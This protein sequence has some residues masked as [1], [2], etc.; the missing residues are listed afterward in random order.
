MAVTALILL[1]TTYLT[2]RAAKGADT[3]YTPTGPD[4]LGSSRISSARR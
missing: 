2:V 3:T 4:G 1:A